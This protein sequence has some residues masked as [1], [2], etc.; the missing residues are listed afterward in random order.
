MEKREG[1]IQKRLTVL[2][3]L[4]IVSAGAVFRFYH[5]QHV[6]PF[7]ADEAIYLLE[8]RYLYSIVELSWKSLRLKAEESKTGKDL[9]KREREAERFADGIE[10]RPPWFARPGHLYLLCMAMM[11]FGPKSLI[12]GPVVSAFFGTLCIPLLFLLGRKLYG[13]TAGLLASA[14]FSLSGVQVLYSRSGLTEQD[15]LFFFLAERTADLLLV[16][17]HDMDSSLRVENSRILS[18]SP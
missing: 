18:I 16:K 5:I 14:F 4:V 3:L 15:S 9:W 7:I 12:V 2:L 17:H 8:A 10:G 13:N 11:I 6:E 1:R